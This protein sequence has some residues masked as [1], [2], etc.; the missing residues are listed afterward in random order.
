MK[1]Y[2]IQS[3]PWLI[4]F[5]H[6]KHFS[7]V[8]A[9]VLRDNTKKKHKGMWTDCVLIGVVIY[10][11]YTIVTILVY[12]GHNNMTAGRIPWRNFTAHLI[13]IIKDTICTEIVSSLSEMKILLFVL[14]IEWAVNLHP[15]IRPAC[16][17]I[18]Y[19]MRKISQITG[20]GC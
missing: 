13:S 7:C 17:V 4:A 2:C 8:F 3:L 16:H 19:G 12:F 18:K 6:W 5:S 14:V 9:L 1:R 20:M 11:I 15:G 10:F